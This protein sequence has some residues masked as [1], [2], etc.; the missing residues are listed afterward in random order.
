MFGV[1]PCPFLCPFL[2]PPHPLHPLC[3][4][5]LPAGSNLCCHMK[6]QHLLVPV[7]QPSLPFL[8][9]GRAPGSA[10][11]AFQGTGWAFPL[12]PAWVMM[13]HNSFEVC[14]RNKWSARPWLANNQSGN[15]WKRI[16]S[17]PYLCCIYKIEHEFLSSFCQA[18][19]TL[20]QCCTFPWRTNV[21]WWD[22][23]VPLYT[24]KE[25]NWPLLSAQPQLN[26]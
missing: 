5:R 2:F 13:E 14:I 7:S 8:E 4:A 9:S 20:L 11:A 24:V 22:I 17:P 3:L 25:F 21:N 18:S 16:I 23:S 15:N 10:S 26:S 12:W 1:R 6:E 19:L